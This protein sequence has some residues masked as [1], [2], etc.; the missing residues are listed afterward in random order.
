MLTRFT[1]VFGEVDVLL[2]NGDHVGHGIAPHHDVATKADWPVVRDNLQASAKLIEKHFPNTLVL[3]N[4]GNNDGYHSQAP[5]EDQKS[6]FYG[7]L[8]DIWF[9]DYPGNASITQSVQ[10]TLMYAGY[11][12]VDVSDTVSVLSMNNEYM[13]IDNDSSFQGSEASV[14]LDWLEAQLSTAGSSGRKFIIS[15]HTYAGTRYKA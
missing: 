13:D 11:Y 9:K 5:D 15:G 12:R 14:Q 2:V 8:Y 6:A 7:F 4:I 1:E 3:T 10:E